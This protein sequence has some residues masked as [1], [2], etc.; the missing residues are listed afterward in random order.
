MSRTARTVARTAVA[1]IRVS[2]DDQKLGPD[3]Q[4]AAILAWAGR[5]GVEIVGWH[6]DHGVSGAAPLDRRPGLMAALA[7]VG[8]T[9][10]LVVAKTDRLARDVMLAAMVER[11]VE[12]AGGRVLSADGVGNGGGPEA[13]LM[14]SMVHAFAQYERA[15][16]AGRTRVAL[17]AKAAKGERVGAVPVGYTVADDGRTLERDTGAEGALVAAVIDAHARGLSLRAIAVELAAAGHTTRAGGAVQPTQ[18]RRILAR[19]VAA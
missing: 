17:A 9:T 18:V 19:E 12:R 11:M 1:Y 16:I 8:K 2:T 5:E 7:G 14:R 6:T 10:D 15:L 3:A 13:A 4:R